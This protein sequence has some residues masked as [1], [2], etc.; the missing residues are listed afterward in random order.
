VL[1]TLA[2]AAA[3]GNAGAVVAH[4]ARFDLRATLRA[5]GPVAA[6][7][8]ALELQERQAAGFGVFRRLDSGLVMGLGVERLGAGARRR[9]VQAVVAVVGETERTTTP[10]L[11]GVLGQRAALLANRVVLEG[12]VLHACPDVEELGDPEED[13]P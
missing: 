4:G 6:I 5:S 9:I 11:A 12:K 2:V 13:Q 7:D 1:P 8:L 10:M 3:H